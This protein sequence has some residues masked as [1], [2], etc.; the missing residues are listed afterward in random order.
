[1][2]HWELTSIFRRDTENRTFGVQAFRIEVFLIN[3]ILTVY[4]VDSML[5]TRALQT[6]L[7]LILTW[8]LY[9]ITHFHINFP[10]RLPYS[11]P[12]TSTDSQIFGS[13]LL[14][15][16]MSINFVAA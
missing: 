9:R 5:N 13:F 6:E 1:M 15:Q 16:E 2:I 11:L 8:I 4:M 10:E 3:F 14:L 7:K 12:K